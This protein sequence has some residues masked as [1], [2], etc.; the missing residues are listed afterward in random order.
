MEVILVTASCV[1][2]LYENYLGCPTVLR[3]DYG[4][5]NSTLAAVQIAL[6]YDHEDTLAR[7]KSFLYGSSKHNVV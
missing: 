7:D 4:T 2:I 1:M 3:S 6:R 5:E